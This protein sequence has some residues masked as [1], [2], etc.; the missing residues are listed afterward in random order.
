MKKKVILQT[1]DE[2][3][4]YIYDVETNKKIDNIWFMDYADEVIA[5][6]DY[7][8]IYELVDIR[9]NALG[10]FLLKKI[11]K[12]KYSKFL[13]EAK[14]IFNNDFS[15]VIVKFDSAS[16]NYILYDDERNVSLIFK[17]SSEDFL[18][19]CMVFSAEQKDV[20]EQKAKGW[21]I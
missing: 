21:K 9:T 13:D 2:D 3:Y 11:S 7:A 4:I 8:K 17:E 20:I 15:S 1:I 6:W 5:I 14:K 16:R 10:S 12:K 18:K 19:F